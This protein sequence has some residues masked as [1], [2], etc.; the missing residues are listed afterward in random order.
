MGMAYGYGPW[1]RITRVNSDKIVIYFILFDPKRLL[2][3]IFFCFRIPQM[4]K[5]SCKQMQNPPFCENA[6]N[7]MDFNKF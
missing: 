6:M 3:R 2:I 1:K 5:K 7:E 4:K